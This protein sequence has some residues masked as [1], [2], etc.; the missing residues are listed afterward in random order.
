MAEAVTIND[1]TDT[2][3]A[4]VDSTG[5]LK[6]TSTAAPAGYGDSDSWNRPANTT[7]YDAGDVIG[8]TDTS[9]SAVIDFTP[10]AGSSGGDVLITSASLEI[11]ISAVVSG[12]TTFNLALYASSPASAYVDGN[13][14]DLPSGDR[15]AF[16]G[17]FSL[18]TPVDLGSTLY[19][20]TDS[21]NKQVTLS[22][23]HIYAY[24]ITVGTWT[25]ASG[26]TF[27][28]TLHTVAL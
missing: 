22:G 13:T 24:L 25:P 17:I 2:Y 12:M 14:W 19:V 8:R 4:T 9:T 27:K 18:G 11:D 5:A 26:S 7:T 1:K 15:S 20:G 23:T 28:V 21:I 16:I 10:L 6:V 3:A